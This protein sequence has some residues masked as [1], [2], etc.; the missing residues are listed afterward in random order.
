MIHSQLCILQINVDRGRVAHDLMLPSVLKTK[1]DLLVVAELGKLKTNTSNW[2]T[3]TRRDAAIKI[4]SHR[5]ELLKGGKGPGFVWIDLGDIV[6]YSCYS[7]NAE[8][9]EF[10]LVL[11]FLKESIIERNKQAIIC[12]DF[13]SNSISSPPDRECHILTKGLTDWIAGLGLNNLHLPE[14]TQHR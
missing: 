9:T 14:T 11:H 8:I 6:I 2:L 5:I 1:A 3:D 10:E 4:C 12:G 7:P 13:N